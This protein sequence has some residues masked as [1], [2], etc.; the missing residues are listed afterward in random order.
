MKI[1]RLLS[2]FY[3]ALAGGLMATALFQCQSETQQKTKTSKNPAD[4][5]KNLHDSVD[6]VGMKTCRQCHADVY[7]SFKKTGMGQ[8]YGPAKPSISDADFSGHPTV[9]DSFQNFYYSPFWRDSTLFIKEYRLQDGDTTHKRIQ[10]IDHIIGSGQHTNSHIYSVNGYLYQAPM[11]YY[12]QDGKW[13]LPPGY[14]KGNNTRFSRKIGSECM[15]C[16]NMYPDFEE[17]S[18][19]K[20]H[21]VPDGIACERCHGPG[22]LHVEAKQS[23]DLTD[24][25]NIVN[26]SKLPTHLKNDVC[27]RCHLQGN[28]VLKEGKD[29]FDFKP[30]MELSSVMTVFRPEYKEDGAFIM[31]SHSERMQ[32]SE[33]YK[34]TRNHKSFEALNCITCHNPHKSV[35][36]TESQYFNNT[37]QSCHKESQNPKREITICKASQEHRA[38][39]DNNCIECHMPKS[40]S[41]DIPHVAIH[42]HNIRVPDTADGKNQDPPEMSELTVN[43]LK[44]YNA[45]NPSQKTMARAYL[46]YFE[47]FRNKPRFLDSARYYMDRLPTASLHAEWIHYYFMKQAK[48]KLIN[49]IKKQDSLRISKAKPHYQIGQAYFDQQ[50]FNKAMAYF[51][52]AVNREPYN[53]DYR[54]KLASVY[55]RQKELDKAQ[56]Q[57]DFVMKENPKLAIAQNNQGFLYMANKR[58]N[59]AKQ[60]LDKAIALDPDYGE[61]HLNLG[62]WH[63][64]QNNQVKARKQLKQVVNNYPEV[65]GQ[66]RQIL[67]MMNQRNL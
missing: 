26:P 49:F 40:G 20:Y 14:E 61:A 17:L 9:Y 34:A 12:T 64:G 58:F 47:K 66:A 29:F 11:T 30:G 39:A 10:K 67:S 21:K 27:Q 5:F 13:D 45:D 16:H 42:D 50:Q 46:Y 51:K 3:I 28:A 55:I 53:L 7:E 43:K 62:K 8:S 65:A 24:S 60:H 18:V 59:K 52:Q 22:E 32:Q 15:T 56:N 19:N 41:V 23:G 37:C 63:L 38:T 25:G 48:N 57:L 54:N 4:R 44:S 6:Y 33:C 1:N 35:Q 36:K 31:A 2:F